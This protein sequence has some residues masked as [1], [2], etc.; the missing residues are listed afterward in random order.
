VGLI[1]LF[2]AKCNTILL[3]IISTSVKVKVIFLRKDNINV[4]AGYYLAKAWEM[5][6]NIL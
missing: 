1:S 5:I 3:V 4:Q 6:F 2:L